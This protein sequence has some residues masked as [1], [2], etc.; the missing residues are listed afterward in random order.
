MVNGRTVVPPPSSPEPAPQHYRLEGA[1]TKKR[2]AS[3]GTNVDANIDVEGDAPPLFRRASQN[4]AATAMLL[5]GC[6]AA[7]TSEE[8]RVR[9]QQ[10]PSRSSGSTASGELRVTLTVG[11]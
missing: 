2:R 3:E 4:L 7:T 10:G 5:R 8:R 9:Q 11:A 6:P 1:C